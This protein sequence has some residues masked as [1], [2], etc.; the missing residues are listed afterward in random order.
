MNSDSKLKLRLEVR[1]LLRRK[2]N[3]KGK[4]LYCLLS[5]NI[6]ELHELSYE[7]VKVGHLKKLPVLV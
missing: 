3:N 2:K 1:I 4:T 6:K 5:K 7:S